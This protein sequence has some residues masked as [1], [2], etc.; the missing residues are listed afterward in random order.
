[1]TLRALFL[2]FG[3]TLVHE[4]PSRSEIYAEAARAA[5]TEISAD[6]M[7]ALMTRAQGALPRTADG[8]YRYSD[9]WFRVFIERIF[10]DELGLPRDAMAGFQE[11][12]F[13]RFS[14][15]ATFTLFP[16][17]EELL[18]VPDELGLGLGMISNWS[19]RLPLVLE[20]MQ[21]APRFDTVVCSAIEELEKPEPAIF[22][23]A[24]ARLGVAP[25]E[26]LHAGDDPE[27]DAAGALATGMRA[28]LVDRSGTMT[29]PDGA[30]VVS[31]LDGL[32]ALLR[33][34]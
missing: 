31:D 14:D 21:L 15:A 9:A 24:L 23:L 5:G 25:H 22:E 6:E 30:M 18:G 34:P 32:T 27:K 4:H 7:H 28:V 26:A 19:P 3:G 16:G 10:Q 12:L 13:A 33:R 11:E 2:D 17:A 20:R 29:P 1:M 8:A